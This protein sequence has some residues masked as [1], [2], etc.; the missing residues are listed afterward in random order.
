MSFRVSRSLPSVPP[1]FRAL[2]QAAAA[3]SF[4]CST[5]SHSPSVSMAHVGEACRSEDNPRVVFTPAASPARGGSTTHGREWAII[6]NEPTLPHTNLGDRDAE[7]VRIA[8]ERHLLKR[9]RKLPFPPQHGSSAGSW[10]RASDTTNARKN[11]EFTSVRSLRG[12]RN[13]RAIRVSSCG[14]LAGLRLR[15]KRPAKEVLRQIGP[16]CIHGVGARECA[17]RATA[18]CAQVTTDARCLACAAEMGDDHDFSHGC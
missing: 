1:S 7:R 12:R 2:T 11:V 8:A 18:S 5:L 17:A 14:R 9:R 6:D 3:G 15:L 16:S 4:S 13:S 10:L